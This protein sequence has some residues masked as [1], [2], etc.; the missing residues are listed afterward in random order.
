[1][2]RQRD[3]I[4]IIED[5]DKAIKQ[6]QRALARKP[7]LPSDSGYVATTALTAAVATYQAIT[8]ATLPADGLYECHY[9]F[10]IEDSIGADTSYGIAL[11]DSVGGTSIDWQNAK[12]HLAWGA[13]TFIPVAGHVLYQGTSADVISLEVLRTSTTGT[14]LIKHARVSVVRISA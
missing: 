6:L 5:Q 9:K 11:K 1:M 13:G 4:E 12:H 8:S 7:N 3:I 10:F 14:Q 2:R